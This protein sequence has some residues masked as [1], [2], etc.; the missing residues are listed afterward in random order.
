VPYVAIVWIVICVLLI[1]VELHHLAFFAMFG[2]AGAAAAAVVAL[3]APSAIALQ[4]VVAVAVAALG[5]VAVRPTVSQHF[6]AHGPHTAIGGVHGGLIGA[7]GVTLDEV[8]SRDGHVRIL[9]ERWLAVT[10][11][12]PIP[13]STPVIVTKVVGTTLTVRAVPDYLEFS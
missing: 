10:V 11:D 13:P 1:A 12:E 6:A 8:G 5:V 2:A 4:L 7:R 3:I 9:G